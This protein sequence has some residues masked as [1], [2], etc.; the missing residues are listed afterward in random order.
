MKTGLFPGLAKNRGPF[1]GM[2]PADMLDVNVALCNSLALQ[3]LDCKRKS[4][5]GVC[6]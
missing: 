6:S 1:P 3:V 4:P 2:F 5:L